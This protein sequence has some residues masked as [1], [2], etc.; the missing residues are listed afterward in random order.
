MNSRLRLAVRLGLVVA[1]LAAAYPR[2]WRRWCLT[3]GATA[4][5]AE[6]A[7]PGDELMPHPGVLSTRAV[8]IQAA[9]AAIWPWLVRLGGGRTH[10]RLE[11]LLGRGAGGPA[12]DPRTVRSR[13]Q[14]AVLEPERTLVFR[15]PA[16]DRVQ[17]FV[18]RPEGTATRLISRNRVA[19]AG[20]GSAARRLL[21]SVLREP[22]DLVLERRMLLDV[23]ERAERRP[24][25]TS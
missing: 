20:T 4:E 2:M 11:N 24:E 1:G 13:M 21:D 23:K 25:L 7:L 15:S 18:L 19:G 8:T 6:R 14:V 22:G 9:P 10:D 17:A 16:G 3:W 12:W 5:E